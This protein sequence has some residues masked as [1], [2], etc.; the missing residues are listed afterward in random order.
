MSTAKTQTSKPKPSLSSEKIEGPHLLDRAAQLQKLEEEY[1]FVREALAHIPDVMAFNY[2]IFRQI[3]ARRNELPTPVLVRAFQSLEQCV[4]LMN[5][6]MASWA[7]QEYETSQKFLQLSQDYAREAEEEND[8]DS[9]Q[10]LKARSKT[11]ALKATSSK[12]IADKL[13]QWLLT[14]QKKNVVSPA[15]SHPQ[16]QINED[17]D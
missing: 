11:M 2:E 6:A 1:A 16:N 13:N 3:L 14:T 10:R 12:K 4:E 5:A 9:K 7:R 17:A 8:P 15:T